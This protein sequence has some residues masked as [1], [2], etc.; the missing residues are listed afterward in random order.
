VY[1]TCSI[2]HEENQDIVEAFLAA[3]PDFALQPAGEVLRQQH[4]AL[5]MGDYL[6]LSPQLH[7]TDGF[8]AAVLERKGA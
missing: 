2:L 4:I 3:H 5:E 8:F 6:Q 1:A 7:N